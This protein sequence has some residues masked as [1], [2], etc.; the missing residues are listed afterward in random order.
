MT[1]PHPFSDELPIPADIVVL[2]EGLVRDPWPASSEDRD[3]L[4]K[5]VGLSLGDPFPR[6]D[7]DG[8]TAHFKLLTGF[9][10]G[11]VFANGTEKDGVLESVHV[12]LRAGSAPPDP[13]ATRCFDAIRSQLTD[14]H[15][16]PRI[17]WDGQRGLRRMWNTNGIDIDLYYLNESHSSL[18]IGVT[19]ERMFAAVEAYARES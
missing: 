6:S 8:P 9:G 13:E 5:R 12:Q 4:Q 19:D 10:H 7:G 16:E 11:A 15:G 3:A 18:M 17:P 2:V 14:L 1:P